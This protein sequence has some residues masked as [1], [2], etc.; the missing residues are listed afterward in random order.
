MKTLLNL[1]LT[2]VMIVLGVTLVY[3]YALWTDATFDQIAQMVTNSEDANFPMPL[4]VLLMIIAG[5][6]VLLMNIVM[7]FV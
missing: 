1:I 2:V 5:P 7:L 6:I 3:Y 4:S